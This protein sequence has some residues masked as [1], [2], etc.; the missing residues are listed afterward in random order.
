LSN[1]AG[2]VGSAGVVGV[3]LRDLDVGKMGKAESWGNASGDGGVVG[4]VALLRGG[5]KGE[6]E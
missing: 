6:K 4:N 3:A 2:R 5:E 1:I